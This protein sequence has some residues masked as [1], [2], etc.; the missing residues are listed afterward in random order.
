MSADYKNVMKGLKLLGNYNK[1]LRI[2][3]D[4]DDI[5]VDYYTRVQVPAEVQARLRT[6][7]WRDLGDGH[8]AIRTQ[9]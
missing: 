3:S 1:N 9:E 4:D 6:M 8:W 5:F 7:G 2:E